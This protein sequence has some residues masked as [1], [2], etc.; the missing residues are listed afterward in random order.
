VAASWN[1]Y[2]FRSTD[3]YQYGLFRIV[4]LLGAVLMNRR[5]FRQVVDLPPLLADPPFFIRHLHL[6]FPPSHEQFEMLA[7]LHLWLLVL[8]TIGFGTR[9]AL[10]A[11]AAVEIYL[12]SYVNAFDI[13]FHNTAVPDLILLILAV[14]PGVTA[15]SLDALLLR[16][17]RPRWPALR[18]RF[19]RRGSGRV[20]AWPANLI[21]AILALNYA[22]S[23][24]AKLSMSSRWPSGEVLQYY[25]AG[26]LGTYFTAAQAAP[27]QQPSLES[28]ELEAFTYDL[29]RQTGIGRAIASHEPWA[30]VLSIATIAFEVSFPLA[31]L[32][33]RLRTLYF[34]AGSVFHLAILII[35]RLNFLSF[36]VCYSVF[37]DWRRIGAG[38]QRLVARR[39]G[40]AGDPAAAL[41]AAGEP[42]RRHGSSRAR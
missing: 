42:A 27:G 15:C 6:P 24:L 36:M 28:I 21:L 22:G 38:L 11:L 20:L 32:G 4:F 7:D 14:A 39:Y 29:R 5:H 2:W 10:L 35:M 3:E 8:A 31:L 1:R 30:R 40:G 18:E 37:V 33:P 34:L 23:G 25:L 9:L 13:Y 19:P 17:L 16:L 41:E 12:A 26:P